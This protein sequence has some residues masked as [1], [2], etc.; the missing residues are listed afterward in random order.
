MALIRSY[1]SEDLPD[2][3]RICLITGDAGEDATALYQDPALIGAI[4][5]A[6]YGELAPDF[7]FVVEDDEGVGGYVVG[8][9]D[10]RAFEAQLEAEWWPIWRRRVT[11][12][13]GDRSGWTADQRRAQAIHHPSAVPQTIIEAHPAHLHLN[14]APR[15]RRRGLGRSLAQRWLDHASAH[16]VQSAHVG[17]GAQNQR[18][19]AFWRACGFNPLGESP[20][21]G[22]DG[23]VWL[24]RR[25]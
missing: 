3:Y 18:G 24:G 23:A 22:T 21:R 12:P 6:P 17:V 8:A 14:L 13:S 7:C 4:Y 10:T 19:L 1:R 11:A 5:A 15:L 16:G 25:V 9:P 20:D 2:L